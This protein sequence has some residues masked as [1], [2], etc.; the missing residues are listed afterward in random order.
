MSSHFAR[1][2]RT[3]LAL[4]TAVAAGAMLT[5]GLTAGNAAADT[6]APTAL[7]G[8]PVLLCGPRRPP[9]PRR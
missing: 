8:A 4:A 9:R 6:A 3:T 1:H 2:K 7:P 5:T